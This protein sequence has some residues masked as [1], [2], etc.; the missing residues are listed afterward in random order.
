MATPRI[1]F[2]TKYHLMTSVGGAEEQSHLISTEL[3]RRGWDVHYASEMPSLPEPAV[4]EGVTHHALPP[5]DSIFLSSR[6]ALRDLMLK[7]QPDV[8]HNT[9]YDLYTHH[10][11][12]DAPKG[13][14]RIW[15]AAADADGEFLRK[16]TLNLRNL[17]ANKFLRRFYKYTRLFYMARQGARAA[18]LVIAQRQEQFDAL[19]SVGYN[20]VLIRNSQRSVPDS[21][22]QPHTGT[23]IVLWAGSIKAWKGPEKFVELARHCR[24]LDAQFLM[25][26]K[27]QEPRYPELLNNAIAELPNFRWGGFIPLERVGEYFRIAHLF[28]ST[29]L[30]EGYPTTFIQAWQR[31]VPVVSMHNVNPERLLTEGGLGVLAGSLDEMESVVRELVANPARRKEIGA[32]AR[33]FAEA[34]YELTRTVDK[35]EGLLR[36]RGVRLPAN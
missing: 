17:G 33:A 6:S 15:S 30:S 4:R 27:I 11:L 16:L 14:F 7:L 13:T 10:A 36:E 1:L 23:P 24:D 29:S 19:R 8:V 5:H 2:V 32:K 9:M 3:A 21:D 28:V 34:E 35:L 18:D 31:G 22:V 25:I 20:C 12:V 26:G